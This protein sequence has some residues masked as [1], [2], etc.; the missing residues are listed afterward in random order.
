VRSH[1]RPSLYRFLL[2]VFRYFGSS[3]S[4]TILATVAAAVS[5]C[6]STAADAA[7]GS[8]KVVNN[9][10]IS[11]FDDKDVPRGA[12][13]VRAQNRD[14]RDPPVLIYSSL[15]VGIGCGSSLTSVSPLNLNLIW[16]IWLILI[17]DSGPVRTHY[18]RV[19]CYS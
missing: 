8:N 11:S 17:Q 12:G 13:G 6:C 1:L 14:V 5:L 2:A 4:T 3:L 18:Y 16:L 7:N 19:L 9:M 15:T 10:T